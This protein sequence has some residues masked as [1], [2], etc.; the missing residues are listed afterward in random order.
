MSDNT[1]DTSHIT[2]ETPGTEL[3][4]PA[5]NGP[6]GLSDLL[7]AATEDRE[8]RVDIPAAIESYLAEQVKVFAAKSNR[9]KRTLSITDAGLAAA[10]L[11]GRPT[12]K[13][14]TGDVQKV[15]AAK[16]FARMVRQYAADNNLSSAP[17]TN[18]TSVT[19]RFAKRAADKKPATDTATVTVTQGEPTPATAPTPSPVAPT[20]ATLSAR[21]ERAAR[22]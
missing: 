10:I 22:K 13:R 6:L 17:A 3:S 19:F 5:F 9:F 21:A 12:A 18:G 7:A 16:H 15:E 14:L 8:P 20:P 4:A 11:A 2:T 1:T